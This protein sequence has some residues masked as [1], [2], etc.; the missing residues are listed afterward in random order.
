MRVPFIKSRNKYPCDPLQ[1][2]LVAFGSGPALITG[3]SAKRPVASTLP[4]LLPHW[5]RANN[6]T[7]Q[8]TFVYPDV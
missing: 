2:N 7:Y 8:K 5:D 6:W 3:N 1:L 4:L